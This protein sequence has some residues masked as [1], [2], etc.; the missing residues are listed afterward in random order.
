MR[1]GGGKGTTGNRATW[2]RTVRVGEGT[3]RGLRALAVNEA[4]QGRPPVHE[5]EQVTIQG[6]TGQKTRR[7]NERRAVHPALR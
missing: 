1:R 2:S 6:P 5:V 7:R 4:H 3:Q